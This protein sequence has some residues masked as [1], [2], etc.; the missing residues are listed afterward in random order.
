MDSKRSR[1]GTFIVK[2]GKVTAFHPEPAEDAVN[3]NRTAL[4]NEELLSF[5]GNPVAAKLPSS[6]T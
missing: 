4:T 3:D 5:A 2:N 1:D 6:F